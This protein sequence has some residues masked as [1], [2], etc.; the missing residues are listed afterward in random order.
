VEVEGVGRGWRDDATGQLVV[1]FQDGAVLRLSQ[2]ADTVTYCP[3]AQAEGE[4]SADLHTY[5]L[6][7][8]GTHTASRG[9]IPK[10]VRDRMRHLAAFIQK[11]HV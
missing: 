7:G 6:P 10:P 2:G 9:K 8:M 5:P 1:L 11:L 3:S 4:G